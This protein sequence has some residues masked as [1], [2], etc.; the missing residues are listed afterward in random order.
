[1]EIWQLVLL[2]ILGSIITFLLI[3]Y[4]VMV[5][6]IKK[7]LLSTMPRYEKP[8]YPMFITY[9]DIKDKYPR[10]EYSFK[11][12][13]NLLSA[14][15]YGKD[16]T[17]GFIVYVHGM[18]PGHIG[19]L[20]DIIELV[21]RGYQVFTYDFTGTGSSEGSSM[22]GV[23]AQAYDLRA[24]LKFLSKS[25][26]FK[27][28]D[29][30]L[31]GHSMGGYAV[32]LDVNESSKIKACVSIA[33]FDEPLS[34]IINTSLTNDKTRKFMKKNRFKFLSA[35]VLIFGFNANKKASKE[36]KKTKVPTLVF[37]GNDDAVV[38]YQLDSIYSKKDEINNDLVEYI[39][40][41]TPPHNNHSTILASTE[42]FEYQ[43]MKEKERIELAN[44][45]GDKTKGYK[46]SYDTYDVFKGNVANQDLMNKVDSF[47]M[48]HK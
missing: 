2:I 26:E 32:A 45:Y 18:C 6:M 37:Q 11:S 3:R 8:E 40:V 41:D 47:F 28:K 39:L 19:Y 36:L 38:N 7:I 30:Y 23:Q 43:K 42:C 35:M 4:I 17:K 27:D 33:G 48:E 9:D 20:S 46:E 29:I 10:N 22:K 31:Y 13:K 15:L 16:N 25:E 1:M 21:N 12:G 34:E 14:F 24:C 44:Q 5:F